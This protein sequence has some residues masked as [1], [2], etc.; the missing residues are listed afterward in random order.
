VTQA[1]WHALHSQ[2]APPHACGCCFSTTG[3]ILRL[4]PVGERLYR[5]SGKAAFG[6]L[7]K[8][9]AALAEWRGHREAGTGSVQ[10]VLEL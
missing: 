1:E 4:C 6:R 9:L 7:E 2:P 3:R 8:W 10:G 5:E